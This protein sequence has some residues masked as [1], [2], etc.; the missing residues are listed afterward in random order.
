MFIEESMEAIFYLIFL[1]K[2]LHPASDYILKI[3]TTN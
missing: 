3:I 2:F 1:V